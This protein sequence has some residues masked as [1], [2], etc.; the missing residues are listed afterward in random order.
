MSEVRVRFAPSPTG[1]LHIG[2]VR[3]ALYNY[4]L[5]KKLGGK[6]I[7]RIEDTDQN[8]LVKGAEKYILDSLNWLGLNADES[9]EVGGKFAPYKQSERIEIYKKYIDQILETE[10]AYLAF[11]TNDELDILRKEYEQKGLVF[12]YGVDTRKKLKNS[13]T[14][15]KNEV[16][17]LIDN[18]IPYVV[19]FKI[20]ENKNIVV[21]DIVRGTFT[22]ESKTLDDKVLF[23][24]DGMPTY[25]FANIVDDHLMEISHVI[26]GEEWL[27]SLP[28]HLLLYEAMNWDAPE[29][30][31]LPLILKPE[32]NGKLSKRDGDK[33]GFP[34]F[35]LNFTD[36]TGK[37]SI[38]YKEFGYF[39][40][41]VI[42]LLALIGWSNKDNKEIYSLDELIKEFDLNE[43]SK[44]GARFNPEKAVWFNNYYLQQK[45]N[46]EIVPLFQEILLRNNISIDSEKDLAII[47]LL[48][49][50]AHFVKDIFEESLFFYERPSTFLES[51]LKKAVKEDTKSILENIINLFSEIDFKEDIITK[52]ITDF[53]EQNHIGMGRIMMPLRLSL[54]GEMRGPNVP[55]IMEI[56]GKEESIKRINLFIDTI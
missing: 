28:L 36:E 44:S 52:T 45:Q 30:A 7:I 11:D 53:S 27:P 2:G 39:P 10:F 50:R 26:R 48:K 49:E 42:N 56:L 14:L 32:G 40:E 18:G 31:H 29:F 1:A 17:E 5:A 25:H 54:V 47:S 4:L 33:Y 13:I 12:S 21:K 46:I 15:S 20:P 19:R 6:F 35:P 9:P 22:V 23:K 41:A 51:D 43:V 16:N 55:K 37:T 24:A 3:T 34:V 8:R 38:G